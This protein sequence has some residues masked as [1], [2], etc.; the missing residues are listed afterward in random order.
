MATAFRVAAEQL[1]IDQLLDV[2]DLV[3]SARPDEKVGGVPG[4]SWGEWCK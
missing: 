3:D 2:E 1:G 4:S